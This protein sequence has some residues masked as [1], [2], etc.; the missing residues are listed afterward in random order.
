MIESLRTYK[1]SGELAL[2]RKAVDASVAAHFAAFKVVKPN[3]TEREI[4]RTDLQ[5]EWGKRG[6]GN[7]SLCAI[8]ELRLLLNSSTLL[9]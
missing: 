2:I 3:I 9:G 1:D 4:S 5:Y 6:C 8:N 7:V